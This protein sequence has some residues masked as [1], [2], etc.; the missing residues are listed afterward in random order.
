MK[1]MQ[2]FTIEDVATG[3]VSLVPT[4][5]FFKPVLVLVAPL[6]IEG[7]AVLECSYLFDPSGNPYPF[8]GSHKLSGAVSGA[9]LTFTSKISGSVEIATEK[10]V[11]FA[12]SIAEKQGMELQ[13]RAHLPESEEKLIELLHFL[14]KLNK[15]KF[16]VIVS[17]RQVSVFEIPGDAA[18][19][20][21]AAR[22]WPFN[23]LSGRSSAISGAVRVLEVE[24]LWIGG[25]ECKAHGLKTPKAGGVQLTR[26]R[27]AFQAEA[28][29]LKWATEG[30]LDFVKMDLA[31]EGP[32]EL[33]A[34]AEL[35]DWCIA[36]VPELSRAGEHVTQ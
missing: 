11:H 34:V 18:V 12:L 32:K 9:V 6:T 31:G 20:R 7:A 28:E 13:F 4:K 10:V 14:A 27:P 36:T 22:E 1:L 8:E 16:G 15:E 2:P 26:D 25:W 29:A 35:V 5:K 30:L 19:D 24:G 23:I 17:P 3:E 21:S 33:K